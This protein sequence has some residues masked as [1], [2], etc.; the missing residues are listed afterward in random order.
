MQRE[1]IVTMDGF[2]KLRKAMRDEGKKVIH[3][4]GVF[5]LI[6]PGHIAHFEEARALGDVLVVS[7]TSSNYVNKG[8]GRPYFSDELR[9]KS[10]ASLSCVDYVML[11]EYPT[12]IEA[13]GCIQPSYYIKGSEYAVEEEDVTGNITKEIECVRLYGG[14][15]KYTD[16]IVFSSTKLLNRNFSVFPPGVKGFAQDFA[17]RYSFEMIKELVDKMKQLKIL[18]VGDIIIDE[19]VFCTIQGLSSK[20]RMFSARYEREER[21]L[22][23]ALAIA[24]HLAGFSNYV[25]VSSIVGETASI[26]SQILNDLSPLMKLDLQFNSGFRTTVKRRYIERH[27]IRNE[28]DKLF[29]INNLPQGD[30]GLTNEERQKFYKQL[31][32]EVDKYDLVVVTDFGHGMIDETTMDILAK[33]AKSLAVNCQTNSSNY[34]MNLITKYKRA[35]VFTLDER[36]LR[37]AMANSSKS[38]DVL[39]QQLMEH[40]HAKNGWVTLGSLGSFAL[41]DQMHECRTPA[42]TLSVQDTIGAGDAF[43]A[44][45][46]LGYGV[47]ASLEVSSFLGN[48]AGALA[49]NI[50]GNSKS[51]EKS[52]LLKFA[53]TLL[54]F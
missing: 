7:I 34:G 38:E 15:V 26:H 3:C 37:L 12:A 18:V 31:E 28:Y 17:E 45:A 52:E 39:L 51:I 47:G 20:D 48:L 4:H 8:P 13:I 27:G 40:L 33:K 41:N 25:T 50:L 16:G 43:F 53:T 54:K 21:Y 11:I 36:E 35:D 29:S 22:G 6:H 42:L 2:A 44:L 14:D 32:N 23:G 1:K 10:L 49:A 19:Y 46:S 5:D 24:K 9:L 30:G